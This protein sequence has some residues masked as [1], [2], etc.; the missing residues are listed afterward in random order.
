MNE[1]RKLYSTSET[2][3]KVVRKDTNK[4]T[5][6]ATNK[7]IDEV[8]DNKATDKATNKITIE[9]IDTKASLQGLQDINLEETLF[10][11]EQSEQDSISYSLVFDTDSSD[12]ESGDAPL[13]VTLEQ[14]FSTWKAIGNFLSEYG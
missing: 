6:K 13:N 2:L 8:I 10:T 5:N 12:D 9:A 4:A 7:I 3:E 1:M 11:T 14:T